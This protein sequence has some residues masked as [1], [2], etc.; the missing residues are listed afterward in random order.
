MNN[1]EFAHK[2]VIITGAARNIGRELAAMFTREGAHVVV[3][4][5]SARKELA[6][7]VDA[8][9]AAGRTCGARA[10]RDRKSTRLNS[11]HSSVSRMPSSA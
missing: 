6:D 10:V 9:N 7:T 5:R 2:V 3:N 4:S 1:N 11:S 8:A